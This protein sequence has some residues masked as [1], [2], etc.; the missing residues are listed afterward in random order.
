[1][2]SREC[3]CIRHIAWRHRRSLLGGNSSVLLMELNM[4]SSMYMLFHVEKRSRE[5]C[6]ISR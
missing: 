1:V 5:A 2:R 4:S 3:A 6:C